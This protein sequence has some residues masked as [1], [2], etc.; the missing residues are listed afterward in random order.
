MLKVEF[1]PRCVSFQNLFI[2]NNISLLVKTEMMPYKNL[3][4]LW[5]TGGRGGKDET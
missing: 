2:L 4:S 1:K 5:R 3:L